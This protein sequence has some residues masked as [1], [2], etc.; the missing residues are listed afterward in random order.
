[1]TPEMIEAIARLTRPEAPA[2]TATGEPCRC[3]EHVLDCIC[4][5]Y[6]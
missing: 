6:R 2:R 3:P 1:M 5:A 4:G